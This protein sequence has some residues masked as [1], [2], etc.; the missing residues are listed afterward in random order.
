MSNLLN[1][2]DWKD[3]GVK[4]GLDSDNKCVEHAIRASVVVNDSKKTTVFDWRRYIKDYPD[5]QRALGKQGPVHVNDA[6]CHYLNHGRKES[7]KKYILGTNEPYVYDFDWKMYDKLNPGVF[8]ERKRGV[9]VGEWHCFR[10]WCEYGYKEGRKTGL[11]K[12]V[13][14][15]VVK[16][17][18][19][20]ST[21]ENVNKR[22]V[23]RLTNLIQ[24]EY[25]TVDD[26]INSYNQQRIDPT[27]PII[28]D[29]PTTISDYKC[30]NIENI[31]SYDELLTHSNGDNIN[32]S[33][34]IKTIQQTGVTLYF[35]NIF[36]SGDQSLIPEITISRNQE[37]SNIVNKQNVFLSQLPYKPESTG[38]YFITKS[39]IESVQNKNSLLYPHVYDESI[40]N[41]IN[42][43]PKF[44]H[45][46]VVDKSWYNWASEEEI[47]ALRLQHFS[48]DAFVICIC[49]RIAINNY[50]K[51]LLEAI[52]LLRAQGHNIYLL[53]L[54]K[55]EV[56]PHRLTQHLYDEI[57]T[58]DWVKSFT[59]DKK[60]VLNYFRICDVLASTYRDY[61]NHV[62]GSNKIKEYLL[63]DKPILCSRGKEREN[64]LGKDY[65]GFYDCETCDIVPPLCWTNEFLKNPKCYIDQ[66]KTYFNAIDTL[67]V[68]CSLYIYAKIEIRQICKI[69]SRCL[70]STARVGSS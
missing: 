17:D 69:I 44:L 8:T 21:D 22:W 32:E 40:Y 25:K 63:C 57:T 31:K 61:C 19:S 27:S 50:P 7:R 5:L 65:P 48:E 56:S 18:A 70:D 14:V 37:Y 30:I 67:E 24:P 2:F 34:F 54:T 1:D 20:I 55:F 41:E 42:N 11:Y 29:I 35:N 49:G 12:Q 10:H 45:E 3:Y 39:M 62:G 52:K 38:S 51:S 4:H 66:Y 28:G 33:N 47:K 46:Q 36:I 64:E 23:S 60:D 68:G 58:Y 6:T 9:I 59:V 53:A 26:L 15:V 13:V 43:K 16:T